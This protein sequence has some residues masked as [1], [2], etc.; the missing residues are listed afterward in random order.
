MSRII[1]IHEYT[2]RPD[3]SAAQ[4]EK[5]VEQARKRRLFN[6]PGLIEYY[7][8]KR[9]RGTRQT[10]YAAIWIYENKTAW[11]NLWGTM[12]NPVKKENYPEQ[13]KV[14]EN[15]LLAPD[16]IFYASYEEF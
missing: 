4:F 6:L 3:V 7:F 11:T 1:S 2:L 8:L 9:I 14:W 15:E 16:K 10:D 13:W 5:T 12:N